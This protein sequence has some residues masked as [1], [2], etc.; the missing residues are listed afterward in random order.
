VDTAYAKPQPFVLSLD[1]TGGGTDHKTFKVS[2]HNTPKQILDVI[3]EK[4]E[5]LNHPRPPPVRWTRS[6]VNLDATGNYMWAWTTPFPVGEEVDAVTS[7]DRIESLLTKVRYFFFFALIHSLSPSLSLSHAHT[8]T[9]NT[10]VRTRYWDIKTRE[11]LTALDAAGVSL[12][13]SNGKSLTK[14]YNLRNRFMLLE[15]QCNVFIR[16]AEKIAN[17]SQKNLS[18]LRSDIQAIADSMME[19]K[20]DFNTL[21]RQICGDIE[22]EFGGEINSLTDP[23]SMF[24]KGMRK[25][26]ECPLNEK[27]ARKL[28][29]SYCEDIWGAYRSQKTGRLRRGDKVY[30][31]SSYGKAE[32]DSKGVRAPF[33]SSEINDPVR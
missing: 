10:Q 33:S 19:R 9:T 20:R 22:L 24:L 29:D 32:F 12:S 28:G 14:E 4:T 8:H 15:L 27:V 18:K 7:V 16:S 25:F 11:Q 6:H 26:S 5:A 13:Q 30:L 31:F 2:L 17:R 1:K 23:V 21:K 3:N